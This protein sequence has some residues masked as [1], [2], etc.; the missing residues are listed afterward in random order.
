MTSPQDSSK[1]LCPKPP[2]PP[3][4]VRDA[5]GLVREA[6]AFDVFAFNG[7]SVTGVQMVPSYLLTVPLLA[8]YV[9]QGPTLLVSALGGLSIA[10]LYYILSVSMPG[11]EATTCTDLDSCT[12]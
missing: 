1:D 12:P 4:F 8:S 9:L 11:A 6:G 5:T 10:L 3:V 2:P 7:L